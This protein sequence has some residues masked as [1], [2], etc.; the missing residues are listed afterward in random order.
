[1]QSTRGHTGTDVTRTDIVHTV[2]FGI[3]KV[4]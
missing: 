4:W 1:M 3:A 2:S